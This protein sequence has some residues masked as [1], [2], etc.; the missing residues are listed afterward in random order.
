M[1]HMS[2][3]WGNGVCGLDVPNILLLRHKHRFFALLGKR[4]SYSS[5]NHSFASSS[6]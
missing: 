3:I 1:M 6:V 5:L 4:A 2:S